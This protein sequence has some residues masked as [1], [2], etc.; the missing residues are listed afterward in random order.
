MSNNSYHVPV[1]LKEVVEKLNIKPNGTY[2]DG[3]LG[4]GGHAEAILKK[5]GPAGK[6]IGIDTD[7]DALTAAK[8]RL[9]NYS[10]IEYI[11]DNFR[12]IKK[13]LTAPVAGLLLDLG[14]SSYQID[15]ASRGFS[16]Q[17]DG[18]LDMRLDQSEPLTAATVVNAYPKEKLV[19]IFKEWGEERFSNRVARAIITARQSKRISSTLDLKTLIEKA[20]PTWKKRES[21]T[22]IFQALRIAVNE[23]LASLEKVLADAIDVFNPGGRLVILAYHSLED[24]L[25]KQ[26]LRQAKADGKIVIL[27]KKPLTAKLEEIDL[28]PRAR[29][30]K[31]RAGEKV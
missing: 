30:A 8:S 4:G 19:K 6:L 15:E 24:R 11:H 20:I 27:T 26:T 28:N 31:L 5:L 16:L 13:I 23:E 25:V 21:V 7:R 1:M 10:N 29:S 17:H 18:P 22:R 14:V 2:V 9:A 3:T 12:N